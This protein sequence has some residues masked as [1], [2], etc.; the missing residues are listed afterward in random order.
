MPKDQMPTRRGR[1]LM[2]VGALLLSVTLTAAACGDDEG[3]GGG[4]G[5]QELSGTIRIDGSSTVAPL[6]E[7]AAEQF[8]EDHSGVQVT[9]GT[10]GTGGGFEKFCNGETDISDASRPI[11]QSEVDACKAKGIA[12]EEVTVANDALSVVVNPQNTWAKCLTVQQLKKIWEPGSKVSNWNQVDPSFPNEPL[13]L[14]G[15]GTDSGTFDFFTEAINGK[16]GASR[17]DYNATE[18]DN[19]TV[20]GVSGSRG[21]LGYFG[22]S[23]LKENESKV[24]GVEINSGGGCVPPSDATV[25]NG[26]YKPLGRPL[27]I[28]PSGAALR[29]AE[30]KE[31]VDFYVS[32]SPRISEQALF[33]PLTSEQLAQSREKV[34]RLTG[35]AG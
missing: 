9:V 29:R 11:K 15:A 30:V 35:A 18:D 12:Y 33:I 16:E 23:Y 8:R 4:G 25:Q 3:A 28:Y 17:T 6:S 20:Q 27:F 13:R 7:A 2:A 5:G 21:G 31:F 26:T 32:N 24:K 10:S 22:L 19:V 14:F 1:W 34:D